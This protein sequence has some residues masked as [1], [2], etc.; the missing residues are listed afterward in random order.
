MKRVALTTVDNPFDPFDDFKAWFAF[1]ESKGHHTS[2]LLGRVAR[3]SDELPDS[4][5]ER[6]V[7]EAIDWLILI[8]PAQNLKKLVREH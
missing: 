7:E 1:D 8:D 6:V 5:Q 2:S 3:I 4:D